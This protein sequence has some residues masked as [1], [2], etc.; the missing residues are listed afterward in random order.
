MNRILVLVFAVYLGTM[1]PLA[2]AH[3]DEYLDTVKTPH[4]GQMRMS[5]AYHLEL[6]LKDSEVTVY[7]SDHGGN[8]VSAEGASGTALVHSGK[9]RITVKLAPVGE[10]IL[11]GHGGFILDPKMTVSVKVKFK[12]KDHAEA[13]FQPLKKASAQ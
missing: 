3:S 2:R 12:G 13:K 4:G 5:G 1:G 10:N 11:Q 7:L 9:D 8:A 6:V